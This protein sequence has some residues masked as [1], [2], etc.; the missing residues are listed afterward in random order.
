LE[1]SGLGVAL[2]DVPRP[3]PNC[4]TITNDVG[5]VFVPV[6][7]ANERLFVRLMVR[8]WPVGTV[9]TTGDQPLVAWLSGA[10]AGEAAQV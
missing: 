10:Q 8:L 9:I 1:W 5:T 6:P 3:P 2:A 4:P 7:A